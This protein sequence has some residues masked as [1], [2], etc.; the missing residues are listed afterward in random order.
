M[1][2][3]HD[4]AHEIYVSRSGYILP[5]FGMAPSIDCLKL[6]Y[7]LIWRRFDECET[8]VKKPR[9]TLLTEE[10]IAELVL[11]K[12]SQNTKEVINYAVNVLKSYCNSVHATNV[13]KLPRDE[14]TLGLCSF[15]R[16]FYAGVR[17]TNGQLYASKSMITIRYGLQRY[18]QRVS[19]IDIVANQQFKPAKAKTKIPKHCKVLFF[20]SEVCDKTHMDWHNSVYSARLWHPSGL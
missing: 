11:A 13:E 1:D 18:F 20:W 12:D 14:L 7:F 15:L 6:S 19:G 10:E 17:R 3:N 16:K 2:A 4:N 5:L 8:A 9:L